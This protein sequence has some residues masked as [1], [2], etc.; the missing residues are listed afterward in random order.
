VKNYFKE[1]EF[2]LDSLYFH[3]HGSRYQGRGIMTWKPDEGFHLE[4]FLDRQGEPIERIELG[5]IGIIPR[6]DICSIR[7]GQVKYSE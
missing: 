7:L 1:A 2:I 3:Y 5:R 6:S 4:A